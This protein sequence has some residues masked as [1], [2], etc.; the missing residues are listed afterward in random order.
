[1]PTFP[2]NTGGGGAKSTPLSPSTGL[3]SFFPLLAY[4]SGRFLTGLFFCALF[5]GVLAVSPAISAAED[6]ALPAT[7]AQTT[8]ASTQIVT[9]Q[10]K[11]TITFIVDGKPVAQINRDGLHVVES[12]NY[13]G[14]LTVTG[15]AY[16]KEII[17]TGKQPNEQPIAQP[18]NGA[19]DKN[20]E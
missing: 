12:I 3:R 13:G 6:S 8:H 20:A 2:I 10:E 7:T 11:G 1:M 19:G 17:Q 14:V 15:P 9:D 4:R 16:V 18:E 5:A